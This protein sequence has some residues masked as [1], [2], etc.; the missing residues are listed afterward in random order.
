MDRPNRVLVWS[1]G[2]MEPDDNTIVTI[3]PL[4]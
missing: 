3:E 2:L 1:M 4:D